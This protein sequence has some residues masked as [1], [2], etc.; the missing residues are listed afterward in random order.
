[1]TFFQSKAKIDSMTATSQLSLDVK[2]PFN[3][4]LFVFEDL[5]DFRSE[6]E[7]KVFKNWREANVVLS[8]F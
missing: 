7:N 6:Y 3:Q 4:L 5:L 1:M 8:T 2:C